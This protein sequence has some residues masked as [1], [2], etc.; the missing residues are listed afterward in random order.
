[1]PAKNPNNEP[2]SR[3]QR[4][5]RL[6]YTGVA[7]LSF[8]S[9]L[10]SVMW[11]TV[12]VNQLIETNIEPAKSVWH[13]L[14]RDFDL[15]WLG[16][17]AH[18]VA[19]MFGFSYLIGCRAFL[20]EGIEGLRKS[21]AGMALAGLCLMV[22]IVNRGISNG[23]GDGMRYGSNILHLFAAYIKKLIK[24]GLTPKSFGPLEIASVLL[25]SWGSVSAAMT[26]WKKSAEPITE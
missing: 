2:E 8:L 21:F 20:R 15:A 7:I 12:A 6:S 24:Q 23:S 4:V 5:L 11:A 13:L 14:R 22:S 3:F 18:F 9:Q 10:V 1:M 16:T 19:G 17:N 26:I 25:L